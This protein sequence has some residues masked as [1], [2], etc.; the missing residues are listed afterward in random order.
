MQFCLQLVRRAFGA[1]TVMRPAL[2]ITLALQLAA[3]QHVR[4]QAVP[5]VVIDTFDFDFD[6]TA[7]LS[8]SW[9]RLHKVA[10]QL[11]S[12]SWDTLD[13]TLATGPGWHSD[14][15]LLLVTLS[16]RLPPEP[17]RTPEILRYYE[18]FPGTASFRRAH[19]PDGFSTLDISPDGH[20][21]A[22]V[23][24][25]AE[26]IF[27]Q[28]WQLPAY[29]VVGRGEYLTCL[30]TDT[31]FGFEWEAHALIWRRATCEGAIPL[32]RIPNPGGQGTAA[33]RSPS[34]DT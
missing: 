18:Y 27:A 20:F 12:G 3:V 26:G 16:F 24:H 23:T 34:A 15:S 6:A 2:L 28:L 29:R 22:N 9:Y 33:S 7:E 13:F 10:V 21:A 4:C 11:S 30:A 1:S 32:P 31:F 19:L 8:G 17:I 14:S 5:W 25:D